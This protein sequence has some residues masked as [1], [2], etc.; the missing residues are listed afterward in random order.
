MHACFR[1]IKHGR[2]RELFLI[3]SPTLLKV[4]TLPGWGSTVTAPCMPSTPSRA[5]LV[6]A[7]AQTWPQTLMQCLLAWRTQSSPMW[8]RLQ[9]EV[10][11]GKEWRTKLTMYVTK[12]H[13]VHT[14]LWKNNFN[15][16]I[17]K[18]NVRE[19]I[20]LV[21]LR[22][23][24]KRVSLSEKY[25]NTE[26]NPLSLFVGISVFFAWVEATFSSQ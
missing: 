14:R 16:M 17:C 13:L 23:V 25:N 11:S 9:M 22:I 8:L 24:K 26:T 10:S 1:Q 20:T 19:S 18:K 7:Q 2:S 12:L 6:C 3:N 21:I 5:S 4:M 15:L